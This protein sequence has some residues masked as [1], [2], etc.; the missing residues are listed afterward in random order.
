MTGEFIFLVIV[1]IVLLI[2]GD[3]VSRAGAAPAVVVTYFASSFLLLAVG[4]SGILVT[5]FA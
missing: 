4:V 5:R 3:L 2:R 1:G